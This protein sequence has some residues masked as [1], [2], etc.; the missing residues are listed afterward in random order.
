MEPGPC[1]AL[2]SAEFALLA[3]TAQLK[4]LSHQLV[5]ILA[6]IRS[7]VTCS[8]LYAQMLTS[9]IMAKLC[10]LALFGIMLI[11]VPLVIACLALTATTVP[12]V[13]WSRVQL[14]PTAQL[15]ILLV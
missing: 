11:V 5:V 8:V 6:T 1:Q 10:H 7:V 15:K 2:S 3:M 4:T 9:V 13:F 14:E 12:K